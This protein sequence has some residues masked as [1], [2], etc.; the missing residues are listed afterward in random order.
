LNPWDK[1]R[2]TG[3][4]SAGDGGIIAAGLAVL[5]IGSDVAGS[6]KIPCAFNGIYGFR[7]TPHRMPYDKT[8]F[9]N[10]NRISLLDEAMKSV[11]GPMGKSVDDLV[12]VVDIW[13]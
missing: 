6:I 7:S 11:V 4:S 1:T 5:S 12:A 13:M 9:D 2:T 10:M 3:G 8:L